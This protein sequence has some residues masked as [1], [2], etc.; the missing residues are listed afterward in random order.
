M[1]KSSLYYKPAEMSSLEQKLMNLM[2]EIFTEEPSFGSRR[3]TT[4]LKRSGYEVNRKRV[5]RLMKI[6]GIEAIYPKPKKTS[7]SNPEHK[8]YPYLLKNLQIDRP[9]FVWASDI[10]YIRMRQGFIYLTVVMDWFSRYVVSWEVSIS[11]ES[12]F[13]VEA[14]ERALRLDK[15]KIFNTDQGSQYTSTSFIGVLS[16]EEI[17]ISMCGKGRCFDNIFVERLWRS[18]KQEEVYV[19]DYRDVQ[20]AVKELGE[21]FEKY[22]QRRPHQALDYKTPAEVHFS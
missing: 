3:L 12:D 11:L 19:K 22:N 17:E 7:I 6:M 13:C 9:C 14:L 21:Y 2:D 5:S 4:M 8:K 20:E 16:R 18:V 10:T 1:A 15:P